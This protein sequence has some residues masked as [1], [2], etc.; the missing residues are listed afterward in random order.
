MKSAQLTAAQI[1]AELTASSPSRVGEWRALRRRWSKQL[2]VEPAPNVIK[3]ALGVVNAGPWGRVTAY[4]LISSHPGGINALTMRTLDQLGRGMS[5]WV[6]VDTFGCYLAGPAWREGRLPTRR[7]HAWLRS[8]DRWQRRLGVVCT[9]ALN[10]PARGGRGDSKR[11]LVVCRR[12]VDDRDDMV[13]KAVSWAL[14]SLVPWDRHGV[15]RFVDE[16]EPRLAKRVTREVRTKLR[17]GRKNP[18]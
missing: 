7:V 18:K 6:S 17:T 10:V 16:Y 1:R 8:P 5:D 9:V 13:V 12:V 14:R 11:T 3:L 15:E 4:E 2:R